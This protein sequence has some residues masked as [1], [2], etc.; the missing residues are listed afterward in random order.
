M[1]SLKI[2]KRIGALVIA[3][4]AAIAMMIGIATV[5]ESSA[6]AVALTG[7]FQYCTS[8]NVVPVSTAKASSG[9]QLFTVKA[10]TTPPY[11]AVFNSYTGTGS[12]QSLQMRYSSNW[13]VSGSYQYF[14]RPYVN[15]N[16]TSTIT[17]HG[18]YP[19]GGEAIG[20]QVLYHV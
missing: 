8:S 19:G 11:S 7:Y 5:T 9:C 16:K 17:Q 14:Y 6:N 20:V 2:Q 15:L 4:C 1:K 18:A 13:F 3:V 12:G 10:T